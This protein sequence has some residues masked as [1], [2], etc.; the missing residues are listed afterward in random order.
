MLS[1]LE[2]LELSILEILDKIMR[3]I[4]IMRSILG[5]LDRIVLSIVERLD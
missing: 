3:F 5:R 2:R 4:K 1:I